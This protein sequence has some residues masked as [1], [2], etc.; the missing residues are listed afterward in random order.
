MLFNLIMA[1]FF[2]LIIQ[3]FSNGFIDEIVYNKDIAA[4]QKAF[5]SVR[6]FGLFISAIFL[7]INA[8]FLASGKTWAILV[9]TGTFAFT[10]IIFDYLLVFGIGPFPEMG[11][12]GAA[13]AS[14]LGEISA[15]IVLIIIAFRTGIAHEFELFKRLEITMAQVRRLLVVG[16]PLMVQ[17]F[18][19][20]ATWTI[21][22]IWIEHMGKYELTVSQNIRSVYFLAFVPIFGFGATTKTYISQYL[23]NMQSDQIRSIIQKVQLLSVS[24]LLIIFHGALLYP[25][26]LISLINPNE[27]YT[28]ESGNILRLVF[29]SILIYA[30]MSPYFQTINGSG[31][32]R[33][34]LIIEIFAIIIYLGSAYWFIKVLSWEI[35]WVW[36]VEYVYFIT[37]GVFSL[38]YLRLFNWRKRMF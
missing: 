30:F 22:F 24:S 13:L 36:L 31:N 6:S 1:L 38:A 8:F 19:A 15:V 12:K 16:F 9:S 10:N 21:F 4:E 23:G 37:L 33:I 26:E 35:T 11:I 5:L 7:S 3:F 17:G 25:A 28:A 27:A 32:T 34:T 14:V 2:Y 29:G 18:L 20:L